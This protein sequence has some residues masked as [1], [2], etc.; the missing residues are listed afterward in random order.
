MLS[1]MA[2]SLVLPFDRVH[3]PVLDTEIGSSV[4]EV[5][6]LVAWTAYFPSKSVTFDI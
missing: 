4:L 3:A 6:A 5:H 2:S 1:S